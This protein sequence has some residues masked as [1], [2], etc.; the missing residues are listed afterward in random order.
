MWEIAKKL[1]HKSNGIN[2]DLLK[3]IE[4][5]LSDRYQRV[6]L[7]GQTSRWNKI[8]AGVHQESILGPLFFLIHIND[9]SSELC[10]SPNLFADDTSLFS[11]VKNVNETAK[12]LN[13][14]FENVS[15]WTHQWKMSFNPDPTK[16]AKEVLF[17]RKKS[18]VTHHNLTFIGKVIH[19]SFFQK[20]LSLVL[21]SKLNFDLHLKE[22]I[23]IVNN[24][25]S[26]L[27]KLRYSIYRR[28]LLSTYKTFFRP[29]QDY[30]MSFMTNPA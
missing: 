3:L 26:L 19:S 9:L 23:S 4:S 28:P 11:V 30:C 22:K 12:K 21:D 7:N 1:F 17:S 5:F 14:D 10:Y 24:G 8:R 29:H 2:D 13:K 18:K 15:K 25:I 16:M 6:I 27:R 20:H